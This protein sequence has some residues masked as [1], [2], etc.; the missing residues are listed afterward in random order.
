MAKVAAS[1]KLP[2][3]KT[4]GPNELFACGRGA[5]LLL[6]DVANGAAAAVRHWR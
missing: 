3:R 2:K 4:A 5:A 6:A 1:Q